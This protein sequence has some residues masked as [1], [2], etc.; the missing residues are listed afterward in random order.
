MIVGLNVQIARGGLGDA[1]L[2]EQYSRERRLAAGAL[3]TNECARHDR[4]TTERLGGSQLRRV[5]SGRRLPYARGRRDA[6]PPWRPA[7]GS[8]PRQISQ[9]ASPRT[10]SLERE[11][12]ERDE[13]RG[14]RHERPPSEQR[15]G[16][17]TQQPV[18]GRVPSRLTQFDP[19]R[20][21]RHVPE[22]VFRQDVQAWPRRNARA[23]SGTRLAHDVSRAGPTSRH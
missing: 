17:V 14:R 7:H 4:R 12:T 11:A 9:S 23:I 20:P 18:G 1:T 3:G 8:R 10:T 19:A 13:G 5:G 6:S 15:A 16:H 2:P 21:A 22:H